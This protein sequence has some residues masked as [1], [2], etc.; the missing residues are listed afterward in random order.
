MNNYKYVLFFALAIP[1]IIYAQEY[2][3][4]YLRKYLLPDEIADYKDINQRGLDGHAWGGGDMENLEKYDAILKNPPKAPLK[5]IRTFAEKIEQTKDYRDDLKTKQAREIR[6]RE[7]L[8]ADY[9]PNSSGKGTFNII[10]VNTINRGIARRAREIADTEAQLK[11]MEAKM[12]IMRTPTTPP[13]RVN[14]NINYIS[15]S[16]ESSGRSNQIRNLQAEREALQR[17]VEVLQQNAARHA[18]VVEEIKLANQAKKITQPKDIPNSK[19]I[20][21]TPKPWGIGKLFKFF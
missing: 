11:S 7:K 3:D 21:K 15:P 14:P 9:S 4:E 10:E 18:A 5:E 12:V 16:E 20:Q 19:P 2:S 17:E 13:A 6:A 1:S 8:M